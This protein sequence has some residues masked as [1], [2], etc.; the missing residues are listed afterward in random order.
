MR[1]F[2]AD[3][4]SLRWQ[5]N[6]ILGLGTGVVTV[7][8][9]LLVSGFLV[10][11]LKEGMKQKSRAVA[12]LL[13]ANLGAAVEFDDK[14]AAVEAFSGLTQDGEFEY[15]KVVTKK[16]AVFAT[17]GKLPRWRGFRVSRSD[18]PE[19]LEKNG[20]IHTS[21][22]IV[23]GDQL[24][25]HLQIG[26]SLSAI[27]DRSSDIRVGG[28]VVCALLILALTFYFSYAMNR[29]IVRP[30]SQM[31]S[32]VHEVGD[33]DLR[34]TKFTSTGSI[35]ID[36]LAS[37]FDRM[38]KALQKQVIAIKGLT[39]DMSET[40]RE[41]AD[42][43]ANLASSATEQASA[44]TETAATVQEMETSSESAANNANR[45]VEAAG[46]SSEASTRGRQAVTAAHNIMLKIRE[47][48]QGISD[49]SADLLASV[50]EVGS[51]I[52]S[53]TAIA[54][55][56]KILAV[57]A[58]IEAAKAGEYGSGFAVVAQ[59]V[60]DLAEQSKEATVQITSALNAIRVAIE[61][62]V[63]TAGAGAQRTEE[64]VT[65]IANSGAIMNDLGEAIRENSEGANIISA[66]VKQQTIG[67]KQIGTAIGQIKTVAEEN[68]GISRTIEQ[69]VGRMDSG[70]KELL[71]LTDRWQVPEKPD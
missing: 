29:T 21:R 38:A 51:I 32:F 40:S 6:L 62:V 7:T 2:R 63:G 8:T 19:I 36:R 31:A 4:R 65:M 68:T 66:N 9:M 13:S 22:P 35:E 64:G 45:I 11:Q 44:V 30:M 16:G 53:V 23:R 71:E 50:E 41:G 49:K 33:G 26:Y 5:I 3:I 28:I 58:S 42:A 12:S 48:S 17:L 46:K 60:K 59:E 55:Q 69:I 57:N 54:D 61:N 39:R 18:F 10:N 14:E 15:A 25:G 34:K 52:G 1:L 27:M 56:S 24:L 37:S 20:S 47:D 67:L 43:V 70:M